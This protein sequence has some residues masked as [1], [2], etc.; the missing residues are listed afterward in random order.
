MVAKGDCRRVGK[1][2]GEW[3][4]SRPRA[5]E[6]S[7][8]NRNLYVAF[9]TL[10]DLHLLQV[11]FQNDIRNTRRAGGWFCLMGEES[12]WPRVGLRHMRRA[13]PL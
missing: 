8:I 5:E 10:S 12:D 9:A 4:S 7:V 1:I 13:T 2:I 3:E 6:L 11:S